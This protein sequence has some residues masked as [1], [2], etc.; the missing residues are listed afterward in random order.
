M[1]RFRDHQRV[2]CSDPVIISPWFNFVCNTSAKYGILD[3]DTYK[4][5]E[6]NFQIGVGRS[7]NVFTASERCLKPLGAQL[8]DHEYV[9]FAVGINVMG[10]RS[11]ELRA[12]RKSKLG[13]VNYA[14]SERKKDKKER[15]QKGETLS[16]AETEGLISRITVKAVVDKEKREESR[17][18]GAGNNGIVDNTTLLKHH[19]H[20]P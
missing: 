18:A 20:D 10:G 15:N 17:K 6:T 8:D 11:E 19:K 16:L 12:A 5:D 14:T 3:E 1:T 2:L 7:V 9:I 13:G 4:F